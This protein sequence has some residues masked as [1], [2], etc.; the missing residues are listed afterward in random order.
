MI[1]W[2]DPDTH[3]GLKNINAETMEFETDL[4]TF[5]ADAACVVLAS[6][7]E[8]LHSQLVSLMVTGRL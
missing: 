6:V 1:E 2:I 5:K 8:Q 3:G 7:Q 4:D